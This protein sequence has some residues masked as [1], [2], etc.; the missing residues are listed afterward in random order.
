MSLLSLL[1]FFAT[2]MLIIFIIL[3]IYRQRI[4]WIFGSIG[5]GVY[6]FVLFQ[7]GLFFQSGLQIYYIAMAAYGFVAWTKNQ[8]DSGVLIVAYWRSRP[9]NFA[10]FAVLIAI[11][12]VASSTIAITTQKSF[13]GIMF[14]DASIATVAV[15]ATYLQTRSKIEGWYYWIF[16][17]T[18]VTVVAFLSGLY[19][20]SL[21]GMFMVVMNIYGS[22]QWRRQYD[23]QEQQPLEPQ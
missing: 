8:G 2:T 13:S 9:T 22:I 14:A 16:V 7:T 5:W 6:C 3:I 10:T 1:S 15:F 18:L 23:L 4:G 20:L 12:F 21:L 19:F 11:A 17:N